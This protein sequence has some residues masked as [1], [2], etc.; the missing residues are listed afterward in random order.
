MSSLPD[1]ELNRPH[2][3]YRCYAADGSLLY[4]GCAADVEGRMF[5]HLHLCNAWKQPNGTLR[6]H[7]ARY[8][9]TR[10]PTKAEA[11][12]A[13]RRAITT[14]RPL[15]NKQHNPARFQRLPVGSTYAL[16]EPVHPLTSAAFP[17]LLRVVR[18]EQLA[19][20]A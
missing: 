9:E 19:D 20:T 2:S 11:R 8:D 12:A 16:V 4:V 6:R 13:E 15:L 17:D 3:V 10:Y 14:E 5:H 18:G 7:M 1:A